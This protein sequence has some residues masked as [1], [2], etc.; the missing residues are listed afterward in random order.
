MACLKPSCRR[1]RTQSDVVDARGARP[2]T[3]ARKTRVRQ[4][5]CKTLFPPAR[6]S[7]FYLLWLYNFC[8]CPACSGIVCSISARTSY[9]GLQGHRRHTD[10]IATANK[11]HRIRIDQARY[12]LVRKGLS[13][14]I[15]ATACGASLVLS[16]R[17][18]VLGTI[19]SGMHVLLLRMKVLR[20]YIGRP[21]FGSHLEIAR[22]AHNH[23]ASC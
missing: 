10:K 8:T 13:S 18:N 17:S 20:S 1:S 16:R 21:N 7:T 22:G 3:L 15:S 5:I 4:L 9:S 11:A 2:H 12:I 23:H 6:R 19:F 14:K